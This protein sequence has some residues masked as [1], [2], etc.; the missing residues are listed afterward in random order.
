MTPITRLASW[1]A[2]KLGG[3][4][5]ATASGSATWLLLLQVMASRSSSGVCPTRLAVVV[6]AVAAAASWA[7]AWLHWLPSLESEF[8]LLVLFFYGP[9]F[10]WP[11]QPRRRRRRRPAAEKVAAPPKSCA[12]N[13]RDQATREEK[14]TQICEIK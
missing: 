7:L 12:A 4:L 10:N 11:Q 9:I 14:C 8:L 5:C 1:L 6:A 13:E 2:S 3:L